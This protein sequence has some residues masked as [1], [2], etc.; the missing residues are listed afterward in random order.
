[1]NKLGALLITPVAF[2]GGGVIGQALGE[3]LAAP[4]TDRYG[5]R[6]LTKRE[7]AWGRNGG[8]IGAAVAA[9]CVAI[10]AAD[11]TSA[12]PPEKVVV[13]TSDPMRWFP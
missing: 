6:P 3:T 7:L 4:N 5:V 11:K 8:I 9:T 12:P 2:A 1:M 13:G 10:I